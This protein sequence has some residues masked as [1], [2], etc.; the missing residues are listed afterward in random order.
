M[1]SLPEG[2]LCVYCGT[3]AAYYIPVG[4]IGP[5]C[6]GEEH[7]CYERAMALGWEVIEE[8]YLRL[9]EAAW[10]RQLGTPVTLP[11]DVLP[12]EITLRVYRFMWHTA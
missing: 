3:H 6:M 10:R 2:T 5:L 1:G 9:V 11:L 4:C 12:P 8:E 7:C